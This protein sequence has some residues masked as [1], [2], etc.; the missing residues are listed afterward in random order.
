MKLAKDGKPFDHE[1][2]RPPSLDEVEVIHFLRPDAVREEMYA[3]VGKDY[4]KKAQNLI[5]S[6]ENIDAMN[7]VVIYV[8]RI[9][10]SIANEHLRLATNVMEGPNNPSA[11]LQRMIDEYGD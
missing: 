9:G 10:E 5:I 6:A 8:R 3:N 1:H 11:V 4:V 7:Q 2:K